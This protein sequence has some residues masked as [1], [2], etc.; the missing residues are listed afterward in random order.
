MQTKYGFTKLTPAEFPAWI[1][2][3]SISRTCV[4]VQQHHS[5]KPRYSNFNGSNHFDLQRGMKRYHIDHNGWA[6]IGQHF[7]IFPDG[8]IVTGRS[9]N[10]SPA[11]IYRANSRAFCIE[12]VGDFD[13]GGDQMRAEQAESIFSTTKA[14]LQKIGISTPTRTNVVYHHWY[15][16]S[17]DL[18]YHN[19]GQKSCPGTGFFGGNKLADFETNFLPQLK[20]EMSDTVAPAPVGL[21]EW[22]R[23]E[24]DNLNI[25]KGPGSDFGLSN[26]N[27]P[28]SYGTV[29]RVYETSDNGWF[30]I[31]QTKQYWVFGRYTALARPADVNTPDTNAR[32]GPGMAFDIERVLQDGDRVF[33]VAEDGEWRRV[34]DDLW[35]HESLLDIA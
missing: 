19:S 11:C 33:I 21:V 2:A 17:G 20:A 25:R 7:S 5:W 3:Q 1:Q 24:A 30:R 6:D 23:V 29:V 12:N 18:V 34:D 16:G 28:L 4:R 35:V 8:V 32:S 9:L 15:D 22:V 14:L 31:S 13:A 26:D 10:R 27:G